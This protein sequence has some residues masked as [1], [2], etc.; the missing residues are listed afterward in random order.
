MA[1]CTYVLCSILC[2]RVTSGGQLNVNRLYVVKGG[3]I[4]SL[5]LVDLKVNI[6]LNTTQ[7]S[8]VWWTAGKTK[9][10]QFPIH[11]LIHAL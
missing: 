6:L 11:A 8:G 1:Y 3:C 5:T 9:I 2:L 4:I 7:S 10:V